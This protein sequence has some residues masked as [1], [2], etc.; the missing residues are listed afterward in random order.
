VSVSGLPPIAILA[1]GVATRM[2]PLTET[3]PKALLEVAGEPFIAHQLRL[4]ARRGLRRAVLC[5]GYLGDQIR[6]FVGDGGRF[7]V[8]VV[9]VPDGPCPLGTG[10][11]IL[12]ALPHL[13]GEFFV[14]YGDAYLD[15]DYTAIHAAYRASGREALM[16]V[17]RNRGAGDVSNA[18][19]REGLVEYDKR[20][21]ASDMA[22]IDWG[23]SILR[24]TAFASHP[25]DA[26][27]DLADV[28]EV[29]SRRGQLAGYETSTPFHEIGSPA[30]LA[31]TERYLGATP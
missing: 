25:S 8:E 10:G 21:P 20:R 18:R 28:L 7:G 15:D 30:G 19:F 4:L 12:H 22:Y 11:A 14:T 31:E 16:V 29:I 26:A 23:V 13:G 24:S 9:Q 1:G 17:Y 3:I 5:T 6:D 27:F 2:R